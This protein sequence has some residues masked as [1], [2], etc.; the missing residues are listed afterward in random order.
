MAANQAGAAMSEQVTVEYLNEFMRV[1]HQ[2]WQRRMVAD[3]FAEAEA[4]DALLKAGQE[5][6]E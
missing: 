3:A 1:F 2:A 6:R 4:I 5:A